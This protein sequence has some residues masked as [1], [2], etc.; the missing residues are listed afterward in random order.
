VNMLRDMLKDSRIEWSPK[1]VSWV[2]RYGAVMDKEGLQ[3]GK[4]V[5]VHLDLT[6]GTIAKSALFHELIH[7]VKEVVLQQD[8]D[9]KHEDKAWWP[10]VP[11]QLKALAQM[12][13]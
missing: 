11:N 12:A 1:K 2:A 6:Y 8:P 10:S 13:N 4:G 7:M 3:K 5:M 9:A